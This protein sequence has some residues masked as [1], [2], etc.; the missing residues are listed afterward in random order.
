MPVIQK[1][2]TKRRKKTGGKAIAAGGFG[3][4]FDPAIPCNF[5]KTIKKITPKTSEPLV[6]KMLFSADAYDEA[7]EAERIY[8]AVKSIP[9]NQNYFLFLY[10]ADLHNL[11]C[12]EQIC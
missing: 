12:K 4:V 2:T 8:K 11:F 6:T 10:F 1:N 7:K 3:C 9:K 5:S